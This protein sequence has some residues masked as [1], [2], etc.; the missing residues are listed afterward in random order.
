MVAFRWRVGAV[1]PP[2][3]PG[4]V[5]AGAAAR[6]HGHQRAVVQPL[7]A[8]AGR[9]P[10]AHHG[11][12]HRRA[13]AALRHLGQHRQR[14]LAHGEHWQSWLHTGTCRTVCQLSI[15][16][17]KVWYFYSNNVFSFQQ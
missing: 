8:A 1:G 7:R 14:R 3:V 13:Q 5:R 10:R 6:A 12:R 2:G 16:L 15:N 17:L 9:E 4:G 11:R